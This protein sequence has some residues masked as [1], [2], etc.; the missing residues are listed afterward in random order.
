MEQIYY[1]QC[2]V[3]YGL[4]AS[5][6]FQIKR[7]SPGYPLSGDFAHFGHRPFLPTSRTL[8][9]PVLRYRR[10]TDGTAEVA[11]L[12]SRN[13]EYET[14]RGAWGRPGGH[15][16]HG[17]RLDAAEVT[18]L[19]QWPAGLLGN[20]LWKRTDPQPSL[21]RP[22]DPIELSAE[23]LAVP[24]DFTTAARLANGWDAARLATALTAAALAARESRTLVLIDR[25]QRLADDVS[26]LTLAFP[27]PLRPAL[28]FSTYSDRPEEL[29]GFRIQGTVPEA[30]LN[31]AVLLANGFLVDVLTGS[32]EPALTAPSWARLLAGW[33]VGQSS[34]DRE[35]WNA[36]QRLAL[37]ARMP[38][39]PESPW[40]NDWLNPLHDMHRQIGNTGGLID[41]QALFAIACW[42]RSTGVAANWIAS[43]PPGWWKDHADSDELPRRA[44]LAH[45]KLADAWPGEA[46]SWGAAVSKWLNVCPRDRR[47]ALLGKALEACPK[48]DRSRFVAAVVAG[49]S[50]EVAHELAGVLRAR[51]GPETSL[52]LPLE[53]P[54]A[55]DRLERGDKGGIRNLLTRASVSTS[56][57]SGVL[58]AV[59][60]EAIRRPRVAAPLQRLVAERIETGNDRA[61]QTVLDWALGQNAPEDWLGP[62][63]RQI[64]AQPDALERWE[65]LRRRVQ[66]ESL[67][68][69]ASASLNVLSERTA[70]EDVFRWC[71]ERLLLA[72][73][74]GQRPHN[75]NWAGLYL[76]RTPSDLELMRR[77]CS[78][79]YKELGVR[80]W[81]KRANMRGDLSSAQ[82]ERVEG[83]IKYARALQSG[84]ARALFEIDF[85][86]VPAGER[87]EVLA[88]ILSHLKARPDDA[89]G[90]AL[91]ACNAAWPG[92]FLPGTEGLVGLSQ[93]IAAS[94]ASEPE[95]GRWLGRVRQLL[96][97]L[98]LD[99][100]PHRGFEPNGL[101]AHV[102]ASTSR[103]GQ[104]SWRLRQNLFENHDAWRALAED[105]RS[106]T[107]G[108]SPGETLEILKEWDR[109]LTKGLHTAR[110]FELW[111]NSIDGLALATI[112]AAR[113]DDL[114]T[115]PD[116]KWWDHP[117]TPGARDDIRDAFALLAPMAPLSEHALA[118][119][120]SWMRRASSVTEAP[121][122]RDDPDLELVP[123][124]DEPRPVTKMSSTSP[125]SAFGQSRW[126]CLEALTGLYRAGIDGPGCWRIVSGWTTSPLLDSLDTDEKQTFLAWLIPRLEEPDGVEIPRLASWL[127]R[128]GMSEPEV[129]TDWADRL[130]PAM[131]IA[132]AMRLS[133]AALV[134][135][136]KAE[137]KTLLRERASG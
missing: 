81:L 14:E 33:L 19:R 63:I 67:P 132:P 1:T 87:G 34:E 26:L 110:F 62:Y 57:L 135:E 106:E 129:L 20:A 42:T 107:A 4:G 123:I 109:R 98:G 40:S 118:I 50:P 101:A 52:V 10:A 133:R 65:Q 136:L 95:P 125:L 74:G 104:P 137:W 94:L 49:A 124:E 66:P 58:D 43:R 32:I 72:I 25:A 100:S 53:T 13:H 89:L 99:R 114:R 56:A 122:Q 127:V 86:S 85:P 29:H 36:T 97:R 21:G 68:V 76:D 105:I 51:G 24:A 108:R 119:L 3:G 47:G 69:F 92:A 18:I 12:T 54:G 11:L 93:P 59:A 15:F 112:V 113:V 60:L 75:P 120:Q 82:L 44:L 28:T 117:R 77:L 45:L 23:T 78:R 71:V 48:P 17:L 126:R 79:E 30:R 16:A 88:Q 55:V 131:S 121:A 90:I 27:E 38:E 103:H 37:A 39:P 80:G 84:D 134:G 130:E 102:F 111:L 31:R 91:D 22:P 46:A 70:R 6:G 96:N 41:W 115:L 83:A 61:G 5:N 73:P 9:P 128:S 8:A 7:L 116:L 35:E 64:S 2:P